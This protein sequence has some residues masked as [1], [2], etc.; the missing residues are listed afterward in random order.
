MPTLIE[1]A[2]QLAPPAGRDLAT[3]DEADT[4]PLRGALAVPQAAQM[5]GRVQLD[6]ICVWDAHVYIHHDCGE[7]KQPAVGTDTRSRVKIESKYCAVDG[8]G[9][10]R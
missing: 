3:N 2:L 10:V 7:D 4:A 9:G 1:M 5:F 8:S 6:R